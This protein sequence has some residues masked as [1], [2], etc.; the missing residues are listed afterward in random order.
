[1]SNREDSGSSSSQVALLWSTHL[2]MYVLEMYQEVSEN[3]SH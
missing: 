2:I 1:L 3:H